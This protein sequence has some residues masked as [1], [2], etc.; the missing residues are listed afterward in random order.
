MRRTRIDP[1]EV[2]ECHA[3]G[4]KDASAARLLG[5]TRGY[6]GLIRKQLGLPSANKRNRPWLESDDRGLAEMYAAGRT[7]E[8][9]TAALTRTRRA[10]QDRLGRLGLDLPHTN[11]RPWT[12]AETSELLAMD[13]AGLPRRAIAQKLD[14]TAKAVWHR[15]RTLKR[16]HT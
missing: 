12:E 4:M 10:V 9:M 16:D 5:C 3:A 6:V 15:L 7:L 1:A 13:A 8:Q 11:G 14:R 2:R